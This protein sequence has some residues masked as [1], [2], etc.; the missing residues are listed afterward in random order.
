[1]GTRAI[2]ECFQSFF[3]FS[4]TFTS[5]SITRRFLCPVFRR[6]GY[7]VPISAIWV[8]LNLNI[9]VNINVLSTG[10]NRKLKSAFEYC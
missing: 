6:L 4:Q 7:R 3:E 5:V 8:V 2:G 10:S 1:M 9:N